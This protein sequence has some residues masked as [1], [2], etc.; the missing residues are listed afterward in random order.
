MWELNGDARARLDAML[1]PKKRAL[2][3]LCDQDLSERT[4]L[5]PMSA[6]YALSWP[7]DG[8]MEEVKGDLSYRHFVN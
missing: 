6:R 4:W 3:R 2:L 7:Q 1:L 8:L 5:L